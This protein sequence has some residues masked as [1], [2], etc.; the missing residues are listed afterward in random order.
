MIF[1]PLLT[2]I[3]STFHVLCI[4]A[5]AATAHAQR[6]SDFGSALDRAK[7]SKAV[8]AVFVRGSDWNRPGEILAKTWNDPRFLTSVGAGVLLVDLDRKESPTEA[9]RA[10][11]KRNEAA[12][13]PIR[14]IPAIALC[15]SEGR[16]IGSYSGSAEIAAAGGILP[17][18]K[19][20]LL[21][22]RERDE[23]WRSAK[24]SSGMMKAG[25]LGQGLDCMD[26]GLGP[27]DI[28]LGPK[29]IYR[30]ILEEMQKAD[31]DDKSGY[32]GKYM[33]SAEKLVDLAIDKAEKKQFAEA[34][35]EFDRWDKNSRLSPKQ[36]Q[37]LQAARFALYQRWPEK[38]REIEPLLE[39]MRD[40]DP[41]S[42][43]GQAAV[44]YLKIQAQ[45]RR[46]T[47]SGA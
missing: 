22:V 14:S 2:M 13:F 41:D 44:N 1:D 5:L 10:L 28:G 9:D 40:I 4:A 31:P 35:L 6:V 17:A 26:I 8:I 34:D 11:A 29:D 7:S 46:Q 21:V 27:K 18:A 12:N 37:Q 32:I 24:G 16:L 30:P 19:K 3:R 45:K 23:F 38:K 20:L 15:D 43:L 39:K 33:F 36:R 47:D 25:R 42:E